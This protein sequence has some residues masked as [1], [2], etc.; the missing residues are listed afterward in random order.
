MKSKMKYYL[1]IVEIMEKELTV[2]GN[3][4]LYSFLDIQDC[5]QICYRRLQELRVLVVKHGFE[6]TAEECRFFKEIKPK[7]FGKLIFFSKL[8]EFEM[9]KPEHS[10]KALR[11]YVVKNIGSLRH[12][13]I[14][15]KEFHQYLLCR[16]KDRDREY[17]C[18][19]GRPYVT[20]SLSLPYCS[21]PV[22]SITQDYLSAKFTAHTSLIEYLSQRYIQ[23][24]CAAAQKS[25]LRWTGQKVDLVELVYAL[26]ASG[27]INNGNVGIKDLAT[28]LEQLFNVEVG[29]YYRI[30]LE[31]RMRKS[32]QSKLLDFLKTSLHNRIIEVD[33]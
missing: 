25:L 9:Q 23:S 19:P 28:A 10:Q 11:K 3:A 6:N 15:Y 26:Q 5:L 8:L 31:I 18:R 2:R 29:D 20:G 16:R 12:I 14:E 17:F 1:H 32:N 22:F 24:N 13:F 21:D 30:F 27:L 7:V 33:G 4:P